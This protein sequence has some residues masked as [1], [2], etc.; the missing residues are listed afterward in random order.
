MCVNGKTSN[1]VSKSLVVMV[2]AKSCVLYRVYCL[3]HKNPVVVCTDETFSHLQFGG[4]VVIQKL[5]SP[6]HEAFLNKV[7]FHCDLVKSDF[8]LH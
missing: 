5:H 1:M 8:L 3:L 6:E 2:P 4:D 7:I